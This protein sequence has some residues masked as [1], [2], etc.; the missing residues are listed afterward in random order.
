[1]PECRHCHAQILQ[2]SVYCDMCGHKVD[3]APEPEVEV[4]VEIEDK[5]ESKRDI[6]SVVEEPISLTDPMPASDRFLPT[7]AKKLKASFVNSASSLLKKLPKRHEHE[8]EIAVSTEEHKK[9]EGL[10]NILTT[11]VVGVGVIVLC[12]YMLFK[13]VTKSF[14]HM[15][16]IK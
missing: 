9:G 15:L 16:N 1:M 7:A 11:I 12:L 3:Y 4:K 8:S 6:D 2:N 13:K 10:I 14:L 5:V